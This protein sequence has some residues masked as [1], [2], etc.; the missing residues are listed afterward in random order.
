MAIK[1]SQQ[2]ATNIPEIDDQHKQLFDK[3]NQL[4]SAI[5]N[6]G[7]LTEV[8]ETIGFLEDYADFHFSSEERLMEES[9]YPDASVHKA[10]HWKFKQQI[11]ELKTELKD[12]GVSVQIAVKVQRSIRDWLVTHIRVT[13]KSLGRYLADKQD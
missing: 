6:G 9:S 4:Y 2:L 13:D 8:S 12:Q 7:A 1:W 3:I 11:E 5:I 10:E